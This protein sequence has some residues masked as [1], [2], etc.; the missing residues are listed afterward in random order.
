MTTADGKDLKLGLYFQTEQ[1]FLTSIQQYVPVL[2]GSNHKQKWNVFL[3]HTFYVLMGAIDM[4]TD[5][6]LYYVPP[7]ASNIL[8]CH[9]MLEPVID[10][11]R[12]DHH[13]CQLLPKHVSHFVSS[14]AKS[15]L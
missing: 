14:V 15:H 5:T 11:H 3:P 6:M 10:P 12:V 7:P 2:V 8:A 4:L 13:C 1:S 9:Y